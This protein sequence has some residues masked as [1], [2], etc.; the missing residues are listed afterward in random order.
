MTRSLEV[1]PFVMQALRACPAHA[2]DA[3]RA[4]ENRQAVN[5]DVA[6]LEGFAAGLWFKKH[7]GLPTAEVLS[8]AVQTGLSSFQT[9]L[10]G[11]QCPCCG[12]SLAPGNVTGLRE[13]IPCERSRTCGFAVPVSWVPKPTLRAIDP[14]R[15]T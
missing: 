6:Y 7:A 2:F 10:E 9:R 8:K 11:G 3:L 14:R 1:L 13:P 5:E 15:R 4:L 12:G